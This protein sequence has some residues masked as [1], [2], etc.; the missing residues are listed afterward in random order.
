[1]LKIVHPVAGAI[2]LLTIVTFWV[3]TAGSEL[4]GSEAAVV[5]V[6]TAVPWG[7]LVLIPAL[8]AASGSGFAWSKGLRE[9]LVGKK[10][11]R[12]PVIA[13]NGILILVPAALFLASKARAGAFD[14]PFYLVQ[15]IELT[16]GAT[17]IVLLSLQM[18]DGMALTRWRRGSFLKPGTIYSTRLLAKEEVA[19]ETVA[20]HL[21]KPDGFT[22]KAGQAVYLTL[23]A[24]REG[25]KK[26]RMRTF[27]IASAPEDSDLMIATR[28][29]ASAFKRALAELQVGSSIELEGPYG[30]LTLHADA[31]RPAVFLAGGI[32]I[33]LFRSMIRED[34]RR[35]PTRDLTLFYSNR[36]VQDAAFLSELQALARDN[37]R[38]SLVTAISDAMDWQGERGPIK[39]E[40]IEKYIGALAGPVFYIAGPPAMVGAMA[41]MLQDAGVRPENI[42]AEAFLGYG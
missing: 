22:F 1:M 21:V 11:R 16:A 10:L 29:T 15:A 13:A 30:D 24:P 28:M 33:T 12:M 37:A 2:A 9:G 38:F 5:A 8:A 6:K 31:T 20:F 19:H 3:S 39:R 18:R 41:A 4:F 7:L 17:N 36:S 14:T 42:R 35:G 32:G 26:G 25:D 34:L 27:S 23:P 40:M